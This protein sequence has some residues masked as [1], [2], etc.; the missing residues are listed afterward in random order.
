MAAFEDLPA[1]QRAV[2]ELVLRSGRSYDQIASVLKVDRAGVRERALSAL[3]ALAPEWGPHLPEA[4]RALITD[5]LL[6]Q[7][8][9]RPA[10]QVRERLAREDAERAWAESVAEELGPISSGPLPEIPIAFDG[11]EFGAAPAGAPGRATPAGGPGSAAP[12]DAAARPARA[13]G[14][15]SLLGGAIVLIV[16]A[17]VL[18]AV[19][20]VLVVLLSSSSSSNHGSTTTSSHTPPASTS[21]STSTSAT[22]TS[23]KPLELTILSSTSSA[24]RAKG[25]AEVIP[26]K[27]TLWL[28]LVA[29]NLA[30][31]SHNYYFVWLTN[32]PTDSRLIGIAQPVTS[33]GRM[34][35]FAP[36]IQHSYGRYKRLVVTLETTL[37]PKTPG[38]V[39]LS[40]SFNLK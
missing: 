12:I 40:G 35:A 31:N 14:R 1:D 19:I 17:L 7:L 22:T 8:P 13:R 21:P 39:V 11:A 28:F 32:G 18:I 20:V 2:V 6:G 10:E 36:G 25:A 15:S 4:R 30:A 26:E 38:P 9:A 29:T 3:D 33:N 5:Y 34:A 23:A 24:S 16:G 27:G 37:H